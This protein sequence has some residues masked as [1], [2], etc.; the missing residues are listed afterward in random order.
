MTLDPTLATLGWDEAHDDA[1]AAP[2]PGIEPA[3]ALEVK[4]GFVRVRAASG[5]WLAPVPPALRRGSKAFPQ[6]GPPA[7]GD[8]LA[9]EPGGPVRGIIERRSVLRRFDETAGEELL[10]ANADQAFVVTSLNQDVNYSRVERLLAIAYEGG[11]PVTLGLSK[12]DLSDD[13][14]GTPSGS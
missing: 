3:R 7:T 12:C 4:R 1:F 2:E 13:P 6:P 9:V 10:V 14:T 5:E 11:I 8:W